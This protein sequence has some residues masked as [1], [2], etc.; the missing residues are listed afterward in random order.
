MPAQLPD[1][2]T[3]RIKRVMRGVRSFGVGQDRAAVAADITTLKNFLDRVRA[4][5]IFRSTQLLQAIS[6]I[7]D[8]DDQRGRAFYDKLVDVAK[9]IQDERKKGG[10]QRFFGSISD[11]REQ[12][13]WIRQIIWVLMAYALHHHRENDLPQ[14]GKILQTAGDLLEKEFET[15]YPHP[16][17]RSRLAYYRGLQLRDQGLEGATESFLESFEYAR[18]RPSDEDV[19]AAFS[20]AC[21]ARIQAFGFGEIAFLRG[22]H[23]GALAWFR[24]ALCTLEGVGLDRWKL[25]VK[26]YLHASETLNSTWTEE[27]RA[28]T[29]NA[30][31]ELKTLAASLQ[32]LHPGYS[33]LARAFSNLALVRLQQ[34]KESDDGDVWLVVGEKPNLDLQTENAANQRS[35]GAVSALTSLMNAQIYLRIGEESFCQREIH[36]I[37]ARYKSNS[38]VQLEADL[39]HAQLLMWKENW[40][41][42]E[43]ILNRDVGLESQANRPQRALWLALASLVQSQLGRALPAHVLADRAGAT[44]ALVRD[45]FVRYMTKHAHRHAHSQK[46]ALLAM[47]YQSDPPILL[48]LENVRAALINTI[49]TA[50]Q[51]EGVDRFETMEKLFA[52]LGTTRSTFYISDEKLKKFREDVLELINE[53]FIARGAA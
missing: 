2:V 31:K 5:D 51:R 42:A 17:T 26:V 30:Q 44:G 45:G 1:D 29:E 50:R 38:F 12:D 8:H 48:V 6:L 52:V 47:P 39:L 28:I 24:T 21:L 41:E 27:G 4:S 14:M 23:T 18:Q 7:F 36:R 33:A 35:H 19:E 40:S 43:S 3:E 10:L 20:R 25:A 46:T 13:K 22:D 49:E 37:K 16:G 15:K 11:A 53:T 32:E 9:Y 34:M